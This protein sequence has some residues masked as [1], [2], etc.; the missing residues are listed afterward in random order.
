MDILGRTDCLLCDARYLKNI[1]IPA[2]FI[3]KSDGDV[4]KGL[5]AEVDTY[6]VLDWKDVLP[7][8]Q[9]V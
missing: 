3:K 1:T 8:T 2:A 4:L 5:V 7:R 6:V 9:K